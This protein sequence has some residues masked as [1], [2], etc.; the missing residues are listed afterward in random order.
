MKI[1]R[2]SVNNNNRFNLYSAFHVIYCVPPHTLYD[3]VCMP[4]SA[5]KGLA[6]LSTLPAGRPSNST[7][8][9]LLTPLQTSRPGLAYHTH[10]HTHTHT[11]AHTNHTHIHTSAYTDPAPQ[12]PLQV[13]HWHYTCHPYTKGL[14]FITRHKP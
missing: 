2:I 10:T 8:I 3:I 13:H 6:P 14:C 12:R 1:T 11:H 9:F 4:T 7:V 5:I